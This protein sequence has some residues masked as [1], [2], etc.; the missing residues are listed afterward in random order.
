MRSTTSSKE[1]INLLEKP[2]LLSDCKQKFGSMDY[3]VQPTYYS[4]PR[5]TIFFKGN[6]KTWIE[7]EANKKAKMPDTHYVY[8]DTSNNKMKFLKS[9]RLTEIDEIIR[10]DKWKLAP[11]AHY[12]HDVGDKKV[13][14][15]G[16]GIM[17][18]K[19]PKV[20]YLDDAVV[21]GQISPN[22]SANHESRLTQKRL[23]FGSFSKG[24][25]R[26]SVIKKNQT[27]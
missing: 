7:I 15:K 6:K 20:G 3:K 8:K 9:K 23:L 13:K 2:I 17:D 4:K 22:I 25:R 21:Q 18:A 26:T 5:Q 1:Y 11:G 19:G 24:V 12:K 10:R 16:K 14:I 27:R